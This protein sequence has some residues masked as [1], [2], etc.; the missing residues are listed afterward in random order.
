MKRLSFKTPVAATTTGVT[1]V[2]CPWKNIPPWKLC[3]RR[4]HRRPSPY[5]IMFRTCFLPR[6]KPPRPEHLLL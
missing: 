4:P 6:E 1:K 5:K 2:S 3:L